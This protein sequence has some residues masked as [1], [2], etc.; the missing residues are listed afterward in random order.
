[1]TLALCVTAV[2]FSGNLAD[3]F[4]SDD[5]IIVNGQSFSVKSFIAS[6]TTA[7]GDGSFRPVGT[8]YFQVLKAICGVNPI[9]WH[10]AGLAFHL[11]NCALLFAVAWHLFGERVS[12][13]VAALIFGLH[14]SNPEAVVWI[15]SHR[16]LLACACVL[17]SILLVLP[18][19]TG[20]RTFRLI[21]SLLLVA[22]GVL[23]KESAYAMPLVAFFILLARPERTLRPFAGFLTGSC[24]ACAALLVWRWLVFH[25]PGGYVDGATGRPSILTLSPLTAAKGI[26]VR[27]WAILLTPLNWDAPLPWWI[28]LAIAA[29]LGGVL[30][31]ALL[32][33]HISRRVR[34]CFVAATCCAVLP[35]IHLVLIGQ[36]GMGSRILYLAGVPFA[37]LI[38]SLTCRAERRVLVAAAVLVAGTA[39]ILESNLGAWHRAAI[40]ADG[41]C[42][43][44]TVQPQAVPAGTFEGVFLFQNGYS[45]CVAMARD[46]KQ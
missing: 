8:I 23:C 39:G 35:A 7:G 21:L 2:A 37:L 18:S 13:T 43:A 10:I 29:S 4:L 28:P 34:L 33:S 20:G 36:S 27:V 30:L 41:I 31:V 40:F 26:F 11:L 12:A 14:G 32:P 1:M 38:G 24:C 25:G 6:L 19:G 16:D 42:R 9:G 46:R 44:A 15:A 45:E 22:C 17:A 5:Y 3:P